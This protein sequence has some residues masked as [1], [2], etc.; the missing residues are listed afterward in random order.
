MEQSSP[1]LNKNKVIYGYTL[2]INC[3]G[4]FKG[5]RPFRL[6]NPPGLGVGIPSPLY[7]LMVIK[8]TLLQKKGVNVISHVCV[9]GEVHK[10]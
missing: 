7:I 6:L 1:N 5:R 3:G 10:L 9:G 8:V 4:G 2:H